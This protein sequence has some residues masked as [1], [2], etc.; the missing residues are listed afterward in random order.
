M[1]EAEKQA[2]AAGFTKIA[3]IAG[4]GVRGYY[5]KIGYHLEGSYMVRDLKE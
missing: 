3:V 5:A 2:K 1:A 4:V